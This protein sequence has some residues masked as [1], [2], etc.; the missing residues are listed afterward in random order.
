ML[1]EQKDTILAKF[2]CQQ[3][4]NCCRCPGSV[5][6]DKTTIL[7]MANQM[8]VN[9]FEFRQQYVQKD[10]GWSIV[11][12]RNFRPNC[13]LTEKSTCEVYSARPQKCKSYPDWPEIWESD[14]KIINE[15]SQL[16]IGNE[17]IIRENVT[18]NRGTLAGGMKTV[19]GNN[20]LLMAYSHVA[21]DCILGDNVILANCASLGGHVTLQ[22]HVI[23]GGM[24]AVHQFC[25]VGKRA[26]LAG[27]AMVSHD[28]LP[29]T[30]AKG[31]RATHAG[32][33]ITGL[34]RAK[35]NKERIQKLRIGYNTLFCPSDTFQNN[36]LKLEQNLMDQSND[37]KDIYHFIS[38][39]E[40]GISRATKLSNP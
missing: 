13:F 26:F 14:L 24:S 30:V 17:N 16:I 37:I 21:H 40:R 27:G 32:L 6:V 35:W 1:K 31:D 39:S 15:K 5:Y 8:N 2:N 25:K 29:F 19:I 23:A 28:I 10:R 4:G 9:E 38:T 34:K 7:K 3:S 22:D 20:C 33:N 11:S 36:L 18:L 12:N